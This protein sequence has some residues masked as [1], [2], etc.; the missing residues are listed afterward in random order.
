MVCAVDLRSKCKPDLRLQIRATLLPVCSPFD[1]GVGYSFISFSIIVLH[2]SLG[3]PHLFEYSA[4][5]VVEA[6]RPTLWLNDVSV[7]SVGLF[8]TMLSQKSPSNSSVKR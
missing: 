2:V 8:V 1:D 7:Y 5:P 4:H 3:P 6:S